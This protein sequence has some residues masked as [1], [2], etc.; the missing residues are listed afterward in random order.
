MGLKRIIDEVGLK[1]IIDEVGLKRI[2][3]EIGVAELVRAVGFEEVVEQ[4]VRELESKDPVTW[5]G[6][7]EKLRSLLQETDV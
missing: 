5:A 1:R 7:L 4:L 6:L 2:I 3:D